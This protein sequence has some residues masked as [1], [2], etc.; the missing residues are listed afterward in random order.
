ME[1]YQVTRPLT[2]QEKK[3][4][5]HKGDNNKKNTF[6][7][8]KSKIY[9]CIFHDKIQNM[10]DVQPNFLKVTILFMYEFYKLRK[11]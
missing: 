10:T 7:W 9:I 8:Y 11:I 5:V 1:R 3:N 4:T 2:A 6:N